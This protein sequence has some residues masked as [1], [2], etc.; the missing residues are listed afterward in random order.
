MPF[1]QIEVDNGL[2]VVFDGDRW[3]ALLGNGVFPP[4]AEQ[5]ERILIHRAIKGLGRE[6]AC[7]IQ[8][9]YAVSPVT[10]F[11]GIADG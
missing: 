7:I 3:R 2:V 8:Q 9:D 5:E 1:Y 11:V 6:I 4:R 10:D